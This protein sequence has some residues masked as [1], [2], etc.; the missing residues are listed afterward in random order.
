MADRLIASL[1]EF[2]A[3]DGVPSAPTMR[4][5]IAENTDF[6]AEGGKAEGGYRIDVALGIAWLQDR[7][8]RELE[9]KRQHAEAVRQFGLELLGEGAAA[10]VS[11]AGLSASERKALLEEEFYAI[12]VAEKRGEL[13]R[14]ADIETAIAD[15][16]VRD[17]QRRANFMA[18]LGKRVDLTREIIAAGE[19]LSDADRRAF[20]TAL[21]RLTE[22]SDADAAT[23][24]AA[25][26]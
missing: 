13:I 26:V 15:V 11:Q 20:A 22:T 19:A 16:L 5:I 8:K 23:G 10:D 21:E 4:K 6:P 2:V 9:E 7:A 3:I 17:A 25:A 14:K 1:E 24:A 18:R 12:K